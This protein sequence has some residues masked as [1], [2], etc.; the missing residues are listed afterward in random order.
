MS[1]RICTGISRRRLGK[2][3]IELAGPWMAQQESGCASAAAVA[4]GGP[5]GRVRAMT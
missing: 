3:I 2:L 4:G 5:P 1:H